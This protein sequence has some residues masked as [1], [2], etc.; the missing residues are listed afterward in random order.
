M[1]LACCWDSLPINGIARDVATEEASPEQL[2]TDM[3]SFG[4]TISS[5]LEPAFEASQ[6]KSVQEAFGRDESFE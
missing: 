4:V 6:G 2:V 5:T 3:L 1:L